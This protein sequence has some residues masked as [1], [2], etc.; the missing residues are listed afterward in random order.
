MEA[1]GHWKKVEAATALEEEFVGKTNGWDEW[2]L[3]WMV[4]IQSGEGGM[5]VGWD[6]TRVG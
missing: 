3:D 5:C 6:M 2:G 4:G 1:N